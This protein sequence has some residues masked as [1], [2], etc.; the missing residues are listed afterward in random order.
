MKPNSHEQSKRHTFDSFCKKVLKHEA[1]DYYDELKRQR[2]REVSFS[3]LSEKELAQLYTEDKY[4]VSE[5]IFNVLGLNVIVTD[6]VIAEALQSLPE[7]KRDITPICFLQGRRRWRTNW[8]LKGWER[9]HVT[10]KP[11]QQKSLEEQDRG[12]PGIP[13]GR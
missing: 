13:G 6:D 4:F 2:D 5:Q 9:N 11:R 7:R 12:L 1:R 10:E 8:T 3:D